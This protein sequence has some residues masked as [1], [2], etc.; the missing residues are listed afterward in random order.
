MGVTVTVASNSGVNMLGVDFSSLWDADDSYAT[1]SVFRAYYSSNTYDEFRGSGFKYDK[2]G[3]PVSG[4][5]SS[6]SFTQN[7]AKQFVLDG[8]SISVASIVKASLTDSTTDD[9]NLI[10]AEL[11][12]ADKFTGGNLTDRFY[13]YAGNDV[14]D[15][16]GGNDYINAGSGNDKIEG[17][18]GKDS[19]FGEAGSDTF[20]YR[21]I[22]DS[23]VASSGRDTIYDFT[24]ADRIDLHLIDASSKS[25]GNQAFKFMGTK[26]FDGHA[27]EVRYEKTASDT[28]IYADTN[29]DKKADFEIHLDD[30]VTLKSGYFLL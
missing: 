6:Y 29:G 16:N 20:I 19:L 21:S 24:S 13:T 17:G 25:S 1:G 11:G 12:G 22:K 30:A 7:G 15:G 10:K 4:T 2:D 27:G 8:A 18:L 23:T 26:A 28:Y 3:I 5:A 9:Y 14:I